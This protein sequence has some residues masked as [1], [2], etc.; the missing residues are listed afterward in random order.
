MARRISNR[1]G[2]ILRAIKP[3]LPTVPKLIKYLI[4]ALQ[5]L[6]QDL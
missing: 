5:H 4:K 3:T 6:L 1:L 2:E